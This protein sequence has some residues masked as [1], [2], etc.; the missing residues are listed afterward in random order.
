MPLWDLLNTAQRQ[1]GSLDQHLTYGLIIG[2]DTGLYLTT[3]QNQSYHCESLINQRLLPGDRVYVI[4]G[5]G[6][7]RIIGLMG[8]DA[9]I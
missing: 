5:R 2:L 7:P 4:L 1:N 9:G 3:I 6:N 8:K